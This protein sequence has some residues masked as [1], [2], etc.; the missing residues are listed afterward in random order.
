M[1]RGY[2]QTIWRGASRRR[3]SMASSS[4]T[5]CSN[6]TLHG[7]V[8]ASGSP[9]R[10]RSTCFRGRGA[11]GA[12]IVYKPEDASPNERPIFEQLLS[13][14]G[15]EHDVLEE[16]RK[17]RPLGQRSDKNRD[18]ARF[19]RQCGTGFGTV[20]SSCSVKIEVGASSAIAAVRPLRFRLRPVPPIPID[21]TRELHP[22][23][24]SRLR[25]TGRVCDTLDRPL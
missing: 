22:A 10:R 5:H 13:K 9:S 8:T 21:L 19:C 7:H 14:F 25:Q 11:L 20:C 24:L 23:A 16:G 3:S 2:R 18:G 15:R 6:K 4:V 12:W 17:L 1:A